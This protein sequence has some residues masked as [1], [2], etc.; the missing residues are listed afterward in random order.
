MKTI[1]K[2]R[3]FILS[4]KLLIAFSFDDNIFNSRTMKMFMILATIFLCYIGGPIFAFTIVF[5]VMLITQI[6]STLIVLLFAL[7]FFFYEIEHEITRN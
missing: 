5:G 1:D 3:Q 6:M 4:F 2:L 7:V